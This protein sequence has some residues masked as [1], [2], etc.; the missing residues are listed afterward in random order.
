MTQTGRVV[1]VSGSLARV[2]V[3]RASACG[4]NCAMC[5]GGCMPTKHIATVKNAAGAKAGDMVRID[6]SD[7][8]VL[9]SALLVYFLP[10][11]ILFVC[12]GIAFAVS[13][14]KMIAI[15]VG[16]L[17]LASGFFILRAVDKKIAPMPEITKVL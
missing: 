8:D 14:S 10:V 9:K 4:E 5:K 7:K 15:V 16:I 3:R 1:S 12:Y 11:L 17:G 13:C 6:T 2:E